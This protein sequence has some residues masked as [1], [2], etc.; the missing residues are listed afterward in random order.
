[1]NVRQ[2]SLTPNGIY[3]IVQSKSLKKDFYQ[4]EMNFQ[5]YKV[6]V[7]N[8]GNLM[9]HFIVSDGISAIQCAVTSKVR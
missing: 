1:M 9:A 6:R 7:A 2:K 5:I 4:V 8:H 3:R